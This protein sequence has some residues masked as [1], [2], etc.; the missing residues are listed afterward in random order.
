MTA[1]PVNWWLR[2]A[3][4]RAFAV[5]WWARSALADAFARE[6][7]ATAHDQ[8]AESPDLPLAFPREYAELIH[9]WSLT[10]P[11]A[12][13]VGGA[14]FARDGSG[15]VRLGYR[16]DGRVMC[17]LCFEHV[18][19]EDLEPAAEE[20]EETWTDVCRRCAV[21]ERETARDG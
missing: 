21:R 9:V 5:N 18:Y 20:D 6:V 12:P 4:A 11:P 19:C 13:P 15:V 17:A 2:S 16:T 3:R 7:I 10:H 14:D 1:I 8:D